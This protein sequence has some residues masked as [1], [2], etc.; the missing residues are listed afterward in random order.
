MGL[1]YL[2]QT[3]KLNFV[4]K[5]ISCRKYITGFCFLREFSASMIHYHWYNFYVSTLFCYIMLCLTYFSITLPFICLSL[6]GVNLLFLVLKIFLF[7]T[8]EDYTFLPLWCEL[9]HFPVSWLYFS[10]LLL[11][12][13]GWDL[14]D[15]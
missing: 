9:Q 8:Q 10:T 6:I 3:G 11:S 2:I 15:K 14:P 12:G 5:Y 4:F 13:M 7:S 1:P